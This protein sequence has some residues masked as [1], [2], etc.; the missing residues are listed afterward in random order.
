MPLKVTHPQVVILTTPPHPSPLNFYGMLKQAIKQETNQVILAVLQHPLF[1]QAVIGLCNTVKAFPG[2]PTDCTRFLGTTGWQFTDQANF[3]VLAD[4]K[5]LFD[6]LS[7][8]RSL[9]NCQAGIDSGDIKAFFSFADAIVQLESNCQEAQHQHDLQESIP[10]ESNVKLMDLPEAE[11]KNS[12]DLSVAETLQALALS[13][14]ALD[15]R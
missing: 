8:I 5:G 15:C 4:Q 10:E 12:M 6:T 14:P 7:M 11:P 3:P 9:L 1:A 2:T 13:L